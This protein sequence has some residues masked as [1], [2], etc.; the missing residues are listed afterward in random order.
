MHIV[1]ALQTINQK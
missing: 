1:Y